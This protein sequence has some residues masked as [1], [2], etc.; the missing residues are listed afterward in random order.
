MRIGVSEAALIAA[1]KGPA[2]DGTATMLA[3][4]GDGQVVGIY[5]EA[6]DLGCS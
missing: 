1:T 5:G 3:A 2:G 4:K 6:I